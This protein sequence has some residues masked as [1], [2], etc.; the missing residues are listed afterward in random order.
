M[1]QLIFFTL[2]TIGINYA[3]VAQ[4]NQ[5]MSFS[6]DEAVKYAIEN[7]KTL[8]N[9]RDDIRIAQQQ[10]KETRGAGLPRVDG[11]MDY[12]SHFNYELEFDFGGGNTQ[13]PQIDYSKLDAGDQEVL[14]FLNQMFAPSESSAIVMSDQANANVQ[15]SQLI[16][17]GQYWMGLQMAKLGTAIRQTSLT[18][19]ELEIKE[20]VMNAYYLVLTTHQLL[21]VIAC[22]TTNLQEIHKHTN[23]MYV[24]GMAEQTDVDQIKISLS[25]LENARNEMER[26]MEL[27]YNMFRFL[28]GIE[29][30]ASIALSN[31][32]EELLTAVELDHEKGGNLILSNNPTYQLVEMQEEIGHKQ[33]SLEKWSMGPTLVGFY[34]YREKI[35]KSGFDMSPNHSA[36]L[37]LSVPIFAGGEKRARIN[38]RK[39]ELDQVQRNKSLLEDQLALQDKQMTFEYRSAFDNYQTQKENVNVAMRVFESFQNKYKQGMVSSLDLTQANNNYLSAESNY[40]SALLKLL[41]SRL[42]L[43]KLY[44][45]I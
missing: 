24:A 35:L 13:A 1:K 32:L 11:T 30:N 44:N 37:T 33:V 22:N 3:L 12:M 45:T 23:N 5:E 34:N 25:Q 36:G 17:S 19:T 28:L 2:F 18:A 38:Q 10:V 39:I 4:E 43:D 29:S 6:L 31:S 26:N 8:K 40:V 7:N 14:S 42:A 16:F 9:A 21:D 41:Q 20:Q 15:V 27:N